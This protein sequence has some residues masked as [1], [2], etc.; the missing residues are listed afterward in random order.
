MTRR[1]VALLVLA[2]GAVVGLRP[3]PEPARADAGLEMRR[4]ELEVGGRVTE[5]VPADVDGDKKKDLLVVRGREVLVYRQAP[6]G[7]FSPEPNQRFR[8]HPSTVLFDVADLDG[9]GKVEV[10]LSVDPSVQVEGGS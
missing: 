5:V 10:E 4:T 9:D 2:L 3:S 1:Q 8:F 6:D 7:G